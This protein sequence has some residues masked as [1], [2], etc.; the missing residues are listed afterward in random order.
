MENTTQQ[1]ALRTLTSVRLY[2]G[3]SQTALASLANTTQEHISAI[4]AGKIFPTARTQQKLESCLSHVDWVQTRLQGMDI[5]EADEG[6]VG[7]L[8]RHIYTASPIEKSNKIQ[9]IQSLLKSIA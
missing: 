3:L 1:V 6:I 7:A 2:H 5:S 9:F 4:E 8:L